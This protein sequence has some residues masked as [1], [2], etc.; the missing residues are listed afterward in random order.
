M[1]KLSAKKMVAV[2]AEAPSTLRK[3][4]AER[5]ALV[6]ENHDLRQE[7]AKRQL[8]E[9]ID[10]I[11]SDMHEKGLSENRTVEETRDFLLQKAA[12]GRLDAMAEA[13]EM[14]ARG[15]PIGYLGEVP[16]G[17]AESDLMNA[18]ME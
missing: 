2:I 6:R 8:D 18:I 12:E 17:N 3:L 13:V 10:K 11:A 14:T 9:R 1:N 4:A 7:L 16:T 5:D 15:N